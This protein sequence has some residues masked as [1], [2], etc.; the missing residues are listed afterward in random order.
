MEMNK[1]RL[2]ES[3][4]RFG[5]SEKLIGAGNLT[6]RSVLN[7]VIDNINK[8][9]GKT[10]IA[11]GHGDPSGFSC[12]R[13]SEAVEDAVVSTVRSAEYNGYAFTA[14]MPRARR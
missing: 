5:A 11:L 4:L 2:G 9:S 1:Q 7:K 13:T 12:F 8:T 3:K 6:I 14:G 10:V